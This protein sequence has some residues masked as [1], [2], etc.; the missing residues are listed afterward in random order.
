MDTVAARGERNKRT[1]QLFSTDMP[2]DPYKA[3]WPKGVSAYWYE[4]EVFW[5][6]EFRTSMEEIDL[7]N[8]QSYLCPHV[9]RAMRCMRGVASGCQ[10]SFR[11]VASLFGV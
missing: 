9:C 1:L 11:V 7:A 5:G 10:L 3:P 8:H 6:A 2:W 4:S